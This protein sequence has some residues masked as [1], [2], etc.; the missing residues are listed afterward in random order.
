MRV[1]EALGNYTVRAIEYGDGPHPVVLSSAFNPNGAFYCHAE[2][3]KPHLGHELVC[4]G[5]DEHGE[6]CYAN[7]GAQ[8]FKAFIVC[9]DCAVNRKEVASHGVTRCGCNGV[10]QRSL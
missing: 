4:G 1:F 9:T 10:Y 7:D 5:E 3:L 6:E 2:K 8:I